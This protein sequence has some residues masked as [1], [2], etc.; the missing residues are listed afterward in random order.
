MLGVTETAETPRL[1]LDSNVFIYALDGPIF[2][3]ERLKELFAIF[4]AKSGLAVTSELTLAE[5]LPKASIWQKRYYLNLIVWSQVFDL[6]PVSREVLLE[7]VNVRK[8]AGMPKL[9]DAVHVVTAIQSACSRIISND[10]RFKVP[11]GYSV[12]RPDPDSL[13]NLIQEYS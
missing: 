11:H 12:I 6:R 7:T 4:Q 13:S 9:P 10:L 5:T 3:A 2:V 8:A 1:Y